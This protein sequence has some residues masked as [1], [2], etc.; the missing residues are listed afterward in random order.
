MEAVWSES[1]PSHYDGLSRRDHTSR[2]NQVRQWKEVPPSKSEIESTSRELDLAGIAHP[3]AGATN[4]LRV[5]ENLSEKW[6]TLRDQTS[7]ASES[8]QCSHESRRIEKST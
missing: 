3:Q 2:A 5:L 8:S 7:H 6:E 4:I 1:S